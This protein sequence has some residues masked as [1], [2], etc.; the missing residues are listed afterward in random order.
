MRMA[1]F[2]SLWALLAVGC[3]GDSRV[4]SG[5]AQPP[6]PPVADECAVLRPPAPGPP[7]ARHTIQAFRVDC[8]AGLTDG[9]GT[10]AS[11][12]INVLQPEN[13]RLEFLGPSGAVLSSYGTTNGFVTGQLSGFEGQV[14]SGPD[15]WMLTGWDS[16]GRP[17][18]STGARQ[19]LQ[20]ITE[21]PRGGMV[22]YGIP[23]GIESYDE[24]LNLR[25]RVKVPAS[26]APAAFAVDRAGWT[27]ALFDGDPSRAPK[28]MIGMW[29]DPAGKAGRVFQ[30]LGPQSDFPHNGGFSLAQR[31]V[32]GLFLGQGGWLGQLDSGS[33]TL[34]PAPDWLR[35]RPNTTL[36]M[37]HGGTGYAVMQTA[38]NACSHTVEV[39]APSGVR[40]G[41]A[42][43]TADASS[44]AFNRATVGYD[45]TAVLTFN[46]A[47]DQCA[48][49]G[50]C[51]CS[52]Q[53]WPGFF[54]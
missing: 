54:R 36:H 29:I 9:G 4:P 34:A 6:A 32:S 45:G 30:V 8:S 49:A 23:Q 38:I 20:Y 12:T 13:G 28:S 51:T 42:T 21:D 5:S 44:C 26:A 18:A 15:T 24:R 39:L 41:T 19:Q 3:G 1:V 53:W 47:N 33:T 10:L 46:E 2:V 50:R 17:R 27:L 11:G 22:V 48:S 31:V 16:S 43:F 40:C 14:W 52:W 25:W 7:V 37:V 35:A